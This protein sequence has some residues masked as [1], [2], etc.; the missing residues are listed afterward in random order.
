MGIILPRRQ[1][2]SDDSTCE[3]GLDFSWDRREVPEL[4]GG[5]CR[6]EIVSTFQKRMPDFVWNTAALEGNSFTWVEVNTLLGGESVRGHSSSEIRQIEDT[7]EAYAWL[8][9]QIRTDSFRWDREIA[10]HCNSILARHEALVAGHFRTSQVSVNLGDRGSYTPPPSLSL[11]DH[12]RAGV[13]ALAKIVRPDERA[14]AYFAFGA[15]AQ[16]YFDGN[17]RTSRHVMNGL[18]MSAGYHAIVVPN[19]R[20]LEFDQACV[21]MFANADGTEIM[22][23]LASC[24]DD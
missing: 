13:S 21:H 23:F 24:A 6:D 8:L 16:F 15:R 9:E 2:E 3:A 11:D 10:D 7:A 14:L 4:R 12:Y 19:S 1:H 20:R 18:L 22:Q 17:K 5:F